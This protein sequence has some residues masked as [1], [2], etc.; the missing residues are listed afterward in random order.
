ME[1]NIKKKNQKIGG[2]PIQTFLPLPVFFFFKRKKKLVYKNW[3]QSG[4]C[5]LLFFEKISLVY[6]WLHVVFLQ[7]WKM[8][9]TLQLWCSGCFCCGARALECWLSRC[10]VWDLPRPGIEL[11]SF[12]LQGGC[13][14]N[15]LQIFSS[16]VHLYFLSQ[17]YVETWKC[18]AFIWACCCLKQI[19]ILSV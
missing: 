5:I 17:S 7:L 3:A 2:R 6:F 12:A 14:K 4:D 11:V 19:R 9:A 13:L 8:G 1:L 10:A 16:S 15:L 18:H